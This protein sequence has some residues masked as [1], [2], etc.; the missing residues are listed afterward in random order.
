M[1]FPLLLLAA[2]LVLTMDVAA[3]QNPPAK[4]TQGKRAA[5]MT[6]EVLVQKLL[7]AG[8]AGTM[9]S[10]R[11]K[12]LDVPAGAPEKAGG[13]RAD[14]VTDAISHT[15]ELVLDPSAAK[16]KPLC[17]VLMAAKEDLANL[18]RETYYFRLTPKGALEK[19]LLIRGRLD[20]KG[21]VIAG[22]G[23]AEEKDIRSAE[24]KGKLKH[25]LDFWLKGMYRKPPK[26]AKARA[27][28]KGY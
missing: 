13:F 27:S 8:N 17:V 15:I 9:D 25:E 2:N 6:L 5:A 20:E 21:E 16:P 23:K 10:K 12:L 14:E 26:P 19:A 18:K 4:R 11:A 3:S 28:Q 7:R 22:S 24:I 1:N